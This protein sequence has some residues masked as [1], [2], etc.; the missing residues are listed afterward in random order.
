MFLTNYFSSAADLQ[1]EK[2][3][4]AVKH[5]ASVMFQILPIRAHEYLRPLII[6]VA[7]LPASKKNIKI[8]SKEFSCSGTPYP[9]R[10]LPIS[11]SKK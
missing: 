4:K 7:G 10:Y 9:F 2:T 5:I 3:H 8:I 6:S 11:D 1:V